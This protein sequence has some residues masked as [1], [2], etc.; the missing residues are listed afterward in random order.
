MY[1]DSLSAFS[2]FGGCCSRWRKG[3]P[4]LLGRICRL[5]DVARR[6]LAVSWGVSAVEANQIKLEFWLANQAKTWTYPSHA[7]C[8]R[9]LVSPHTRHA[10]GISCPR[11]FYFDPCFLKHALKLE[12]NV[13]SKHS[14][15]DCCF[16][17]FYY[18]CI[19]NW[20]EL[21]GMGLLNL[22]NEVAPPP[23]SW[24]MYWVED[25]GSRLQL[26]C[27][28]HNCW[29]KPRRQKKVWE[30]ND[31]VDVPS[32]GTNHS[33]AGAFRNHSPGHM[34]VSPFHES[35]SRTHNVTAPSLWQ[36]TVLDTWVCRPFTSRA[37]E[38]TTS[39][40][41]LC[42]KSQSWTHECVALSRVEQPNSQRHCS[43][44]VTNHSPGY[45]SV[46]PFH[47]S[48]SRTHNVTAPSLWQ[49]NLQHNQKETGWQQKLLCVS[50]RDVT[51]MDVRDIQGG[52]TNT[53]PWAEQWL[54]SHRSS[55]VYLKWQLKHGLE[56]LNDRLCS[57]FIQVQLSFF[58]NACY[59]G[60][61]LRA[62]IR[63]SLH[64]MTSAR[65]VC[66]P[67]VPIVDFSLNICAVA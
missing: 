66:G 50:K 23:L 25:V 49:I 10:R 51:L 47:E 40:L 19:V 46:S 41:L 38:L 13:S 16:N 52:L 32:S 3:T 6:K 60:A 1:S 62:M 48:S 21:N 57:D 28:W 9:Y 20:I 31:T 64:E 2:T 42:D 58:A 53:W 5:E 30:N 63:P 34:S 12:S 18:D 15:L 59:D 39:L 43:F 56:N 27:S 61:S 37:V 11:T 22:A 54:Q 8:Q 45:M 4:P 35:S 24:V 7:T 33:R 44:S 65:F 55:E 67:R 26:N 36:I 14:S 17:I 29:N